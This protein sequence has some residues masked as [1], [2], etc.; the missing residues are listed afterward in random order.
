MWPAILAHFVNNAT[1]VLAWYFFH[2]KMSEGALDEFGKGTAGL[3]YATISLVL[4]V[5]VVLWIRNRSR[6]MKSEE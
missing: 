5:V 2:Q 1:A 3:L 6:K 4:T